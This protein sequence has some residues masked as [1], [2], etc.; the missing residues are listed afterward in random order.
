ADTRR[1]SGGHGDRDA[2]TRAGA[3][4]GA[5]AAGA[6]AGLGA[7]TAASRAADATLRRAVAAAAILLV[8]CLPERERPGPMGPGQTPAL[9]AGR[10]S[11]PSGATVMT[12]LDV[13]VTVH[14]RDASQSSLEGVGF[15]AR[16]G[17]VAVDSA[18][19]RF[20]PRSDTVHVFVFDVPDTL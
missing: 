6:G 14:A 20:A 13:S 7:A 9:D 1:R 8:A 2:E 16:R 4:F 3:G 12:G 10:L 19:V 11:P 17:S 18:V 5:G 15:V